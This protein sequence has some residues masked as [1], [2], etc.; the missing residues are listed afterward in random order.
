MSAMSRTIQVVFDAADP[1]RLSRFWAA[2]LGYRLQDPPDGFAT[3][4]EFLKS[5]GVP[6]SEWSSASAI[7]DPAGKVH[8][9]LHEPI[10][11][12]SIEELVGQL[13]RAA[14]TL[15]GKDGAR[16]LGIGIPG[17]VEQESARVRHA[18]NVPVLNGFALADEMKMRAS[19]RERMGCLSV[20]SFSWPRAGRCRRA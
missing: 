17:I 12:R 13:E 8:E 9:R 7:V 1:D 5:I 11:K 10:A 14:A 4:P 18:P 16:A 19:R 2:A 3:W 6:E 15:A 20:T